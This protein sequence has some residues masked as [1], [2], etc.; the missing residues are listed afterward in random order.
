M[1]RDLVQCVPGS[2]QRS[3]VCVIGAGAAGI[4]LS[5][6]LARL[7]KTVTL[8]EAGGAFFEQKAQ[9]PYA[10]VSD[11]LPHRGLHAGRFRVLGGTTTVWGGQI[12]ELD[13]LDFDERSWVRESGWPFPKEELIEYYARALQLEGVADALQD[14]GHV[15][16]K[17]GECTPKFDQLQT[18]LSRWCPEPNFSNL[19]GPLLVESSAIEVWIHA[20][21]VEL[22]MNDEAAFGIRCRTQTG[23][24]AT[25]T[26]GL[27]VFCLGAIESSRFFLQP[28]DG[29]LPWNSSGLVGRHFQD[30]IDCDA[31]TVIPHSNAALH[32]IFDAIYL[33]GFKY[34]PKLKMTQETQKK[35]SLLS[36]GAT[37]FSVS[38]LDETLGVMKKTAK[39]LLRRSFS[40]VTPHE[41]W[42]LV[43]NGPLL[44]RQ[45]HRLA[46]HHRV[47]QPASAEIKMRVHCEQ[48][49]TSNS[50]ITLSHDR[51]EFGQLR[52]KLSWKISDVE[53]RTI[54]R[55]TEIVQSS[56]ASLAK[57]VPDPLLVESAAN[58]R[59]RCEDSFHHMGGMRM[60]DSPQC[61]VVDRH[62]RLHGTRNVYIC[63]SAVFPTSGFSNP[64]HSL[65]ALTVRL[66]DRLAR[67]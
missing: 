31:P 66:A 40:E 61:G 24:E 18:Y 43:R 22:L 13:A 15:W 48:E 29:A 63:S 21:A 56:I 53:L 49:P 17:L 11:G 1:I 64:T 35:E 67:A 10:S 42:Q 2:E 33:K 45:A 28:R 20:N 14:D 27:Y 32:R 58:F 52:T 16:A 59:D 36:A 57:I 9:Q 8:L 7:G 34:N 38:N 6:E 5:V 46:M 60:N 19:H 50:S 3:D 39:Q 62:L 47:Y 41:A 23:K 25:F 54:R 37:F 26:A 55:F 12:L 30:H 51:D 4:A 65:L 44:I